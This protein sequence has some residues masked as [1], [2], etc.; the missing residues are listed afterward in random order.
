MLSTWLSH[1]DGVHL[2]EQCIHAPD[3]HYFMVHGV[4]ANT[5]ARVDNS[6]VAWL[7]YAP[8]SNAEAYKDDVLLHGDPLGRLA[9]K[10]Q[11][12]GACDIDF[13]GDI[14]RSLRAN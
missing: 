8:R 7:G 6:H 11:G 2:F 14:N 13:T 4:S 12:G 9:G 5:R 1:E 3:H 10:T